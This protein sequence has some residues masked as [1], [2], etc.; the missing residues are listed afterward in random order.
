MP[1]KRRILVDL[2]AIGADIY[3]EWLGRF[4][5][6]FG[7]SMVIE[8]VTQWD[9]GKCVPDPEHP[10]QRTY[11]YAILE[12]EGFYRSLRPLPGFIEGVNELHE[13]GNEIIIAT[14]T[15]VPIAAKEK[16]E[17][18][19]EHLPFIGR[20][21]IY[22]GYSKNVL[23]ADGLIDDGPHNVE[24]YRSEHPR[25]LIASVQYP[26]NDAGRAHCDLYVEGGY[27]DMAAT[28]KKFVEF[29]RNNR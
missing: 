9:I 3:A 1:R 22:I 15:Q 5:A 17:W 25:A 21:N 10:E 24:A 19:F 23:V 12:Q 18:V 8:D 13:D 27:K 26:F 14:A 7:T 20:K 28:W 2:D 16:M 4:N 11:M 29:F 6:R